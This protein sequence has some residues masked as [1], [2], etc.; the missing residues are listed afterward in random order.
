MEATWEA[1]KLKLVEPVLTHKGVRSVLEHRKV[2]ICWQGFEA[3]GVAVPAKDYGTSLDMIDAGLTVAT[4]MLKG[5]D[6]F[7]LQMLLDEISGPLSKVPT[8]LAAIDM[9]LHDLMGKAAGLPVRSMLGLAAKPL[10]PTFSSIGMMSPERAASAAGSLRAWPRIKLKVGTDPDYGRIQAVH[11]VHGG[12]ILVDAN[13]AWSA[14]Q[15]VRCAERLSRMGVCAIEQPVAAGDL[16]GMRFVKDRVDITIIADESCSTSQDALALRGCA[17]AV[18]IK[19]IKCGGLRNAMGLINV[20]HA[21]GMQVMLGCKPESTV[22]VTAM[23]QLGGMAD[24][25]D[26]DGHLCLENDPYQG[27]TITNGYVAFPDAAGLG[28]VPTSFNTQDM[29]Q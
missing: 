12:D 28:L 18:N 20:A 26:L 4:A 9:A 11:A 8:V 3:V 21:C 29:N 25:I 22:G 14:E 23:A 2:N 7:Q 13:G 1:L 24:W 10:P 17:D 5:R 6:P 16:D 27:I 19:L 15:A